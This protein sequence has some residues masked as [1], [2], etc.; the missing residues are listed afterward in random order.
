MS[1]RQIR[2]LRQAA[3]TISS[4]LLHSEVGDD[5]KSPQ[6]GIRIWTK[7]RGGTRLHV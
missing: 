5:A 1:T 2:S 3:A 4:L 7:Q 6:L